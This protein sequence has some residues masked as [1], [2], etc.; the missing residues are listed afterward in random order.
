MIPW[1]DEGLINE[2]GQRAMETMAKAKST[3]IYMN[4]LTDHSTLKKALS[5][6]TIEVNEVMEFLRDLTWEVNGFVD[7]KPEISPRKGWE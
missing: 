3:Q 4:A 5:A 2:S 6:K 1:Q 7:M